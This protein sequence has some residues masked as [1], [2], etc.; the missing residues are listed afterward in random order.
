MDT[1]KLQLRQYLYYCLIAAI[2]MITLTFIP[3]IGSE[4]D[5]GFNLPNTAAGWAIYITTNLLVSIL[6]VMI[7]YCFMQQAKINVKDD[8]KFVEANKIL[9]KLRSKQYIPRS[10]K[11]WQ[12][13]QYTMKG[14]LIFFCTAFSTLALSNA[15]LRYD[16]MSLL[17]YVLVIVTNVIFG[18][19]QMKKAERYWTEEYF[20]YAKYFDRELSHKI[21]KKEINQCL[22][23]M[24]KNS[25][26]LKNKS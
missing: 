15:I 21:S 8:S 13:Q 9:D 26:I 2:S 14:I 24:V 25:G 16:Y 5:I 4:A 12:T 11:K 22:K 1:K 19:L 23:S 17:I 20:D 10:P 6:N 3:M 7:F 18:I